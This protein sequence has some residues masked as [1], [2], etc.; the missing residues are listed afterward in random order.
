MHSHVA[1]DAACC[2][3]AS[4][5]PQMSGEQLP[6]PCQPH[7][8]QLACPFRPQWRTVNVAKGPCT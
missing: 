4:T 8:G 2:G 3:H 6:H 1:G 7:R 5:G